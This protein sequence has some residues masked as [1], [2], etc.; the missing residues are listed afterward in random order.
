MGHSGLIIFWILGTV[1]LSYVGT[2]ELATE[3]PTGGQPSVLCPADD[4]PAAPPEE[5]LP[6]QPRFSNCMLR[7]TSHAYEAYTA[8]LASGDFKRM[9]TSLKVNEG[10][11]GA[12]HEFCWML[13]LRCQRG[14]R[15]TKAFVLLNMEQSLDQSQPFPLRLLLTAPPWPHP[16]LQPR[17]K[18]RDSRLLNGEACGVRFDVTEPFRNA[19]GGRDAKM[20]VKVVC[21]EGDACKDL[22]LSLRCPPF[23]ATLWR[24]LPRPDG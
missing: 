8:M 20:C 10:G 13:H 19:E 3:V 12:E 16:L 11:Q 9:T 1:V 7:C 14:V 6:M 4:S 15:L 18:R 17:S 24:S 2:Q 22:Q 5:Q 23:L 21:P